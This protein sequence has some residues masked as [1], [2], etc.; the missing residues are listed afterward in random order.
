MNDLKYIDTNTSKWE[1]ISD[2]VDQLVLRL[3]TR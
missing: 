1:V 2:G 3:R